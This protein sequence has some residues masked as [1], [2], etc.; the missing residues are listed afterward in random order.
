MPEKVKLA[1]RPQECLQ[2]LQSLL[3]NSQ[4]RQLTPSHSDRASTPFLDT[5][6]GFVSFLVKPPGPRLPD[7]AVLSK[8]EDMLEGMVDCLLG[9]KTELVINL[10]SR[11]N[12]NKDPM[13]VKASA[14]KFPGK[15]PKEAW[16]FS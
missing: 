5:K 15:T 11:A 6:A 1:S 7:G 12:R 14:I 2:N 9:E 10:K 8:I 3:P 16:K 13:K 4:S